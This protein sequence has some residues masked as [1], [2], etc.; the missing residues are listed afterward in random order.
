MIAVLPGV[1]SSQEP[2]TAV[3]PQSCATTKR[4][5]RRIVSNPDVVEFRIPHSAHIRKV[6]DIDYEEYF[7][8]FG[9]EREKPRM[10]FMFGGM[11]GGQS[12][13]D[14]S[15]PQIHWTSRKWGCH[16]D[17]DGTDWRGIGTDGRK[18]RHISVPFGFAAYEGVPQRAAEY[19][20]KILETM[21]CGKCPTC[22]K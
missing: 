10:N 22:K 9:N 20:D 14:L 2:G 3:N 21:C 16:N 15:N 8:W 12:P 5:G 19:F 17:E 18:W 11:V 7:V 13:H 1:E 4:T 6:Q